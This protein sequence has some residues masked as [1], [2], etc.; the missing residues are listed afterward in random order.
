MP[1]PIVAPARP[2][3]A[4]A[5]RTVAS[6]S[7]ALLTLSVV[8]D[9]QGPARCVARFLN[10]GTASGAQ[11]FTYFDRKVLDFGLDCRVTL[12]RAVL[13]DGRISAIEAAFE[14]ATPPSMGVRAEDRLAGLGIRR[15]TRSFAR[16]TL[17]DIAKTIASEHGLTPRV[18]VTGPV[19]P[20]VVQMDESDLAF[21]RGQ[22]ARIDAEVW[23]EGGALH[24]RPRA[25][26]NRST[27]VLAYGQGLRRFS[28]SA[29]TT[30]QRTGLRVSGWDA[31]A[32]Q[33]LD[34]S[35]D[36]ALL[37]AE[38]G[39]RTSGAAITQAAFGA[40]DEAMVDLLARDGA[41][42]QSVATARLLAGARRFVLGQGVCDLDA[43]IKIG[44]TVDLQGLGP[45][46]TGRYRV[47]AVEHAFDA[48]Q[49]AHTMFRVEA[50]GIGPV[51]P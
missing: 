6:L 50:P 1:T 40:R 29:D 4:I 51:A 12:A 8:D 2:S 39:G 48:A 22:F 25:E 35:A 7:T 5:G 33:R 10:W 32:G 21:L 31:A 42:V 16:M 3:I 20:D 15:R 44:V 36:A 11:G 26:R 28:V 38:L 43:R 37:A 24:A 34:A 45:L 9:G 19:L 18:T 46:F 13:F 30:H 47:A 41:D 27:V 49:G 23:A 14:A 17:A